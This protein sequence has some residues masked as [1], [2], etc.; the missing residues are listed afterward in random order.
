MVRA[1][2]LPESVNSTSWGGP[3]HSV[4]ASESLP[5]GRWANMFSDGA[6]ALG[7]GIRAASRTM[8]SA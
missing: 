3:S 8:S 2:P 1:S 6:K 7:T 4:T 5:S